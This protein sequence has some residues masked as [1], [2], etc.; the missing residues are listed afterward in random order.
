MY[1][2]TPESLPPDLRAGLPPEASE[3]YRLT[4]NAAY[5]AE[6]ADFEQAGKIAWTT[7]LT[8]FERRP[9]GTWGR[10]NTSPPRM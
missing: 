2:P 7:L 4:F 3:L 9:D 5:D 1:Y 6:K 8:H 10:R